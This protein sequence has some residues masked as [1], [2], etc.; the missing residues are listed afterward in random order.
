MRRL[1]LYALA[2]VIFSSSLIIGIT[3]YTSD[4][5][6]D[7]RSSTPES[8][9]TT[10][11]PRTTFLTYENPAYGITIQYPSYW[12]RVDFGRNIIVSFFPPSEHDSGLLEN[13][14]VG[15]S[16]LSSPSVSLNDFAEARISLYRSQF[17]DFH[18]INTSQGTTST[19]TP[20]YKIE[21][22]H[23]DGRLAIK[24]M[25]VWAT[26]GTEAFMILYNADTPEYP[27]LIPIIHKMV[28]SFGT[29]TMPVRLHNV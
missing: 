18:L 26:K 3:Y 16:R 5:R 13:L 9:T 27:N 1:L 8:T 12:Q 24:T 10:K 21:Y 23:N 29:A 15:V 4:T 11:I 28:D 25:E 6:Q 22:T 19:G 17:T 7:Y 14:V 2:I 20:I